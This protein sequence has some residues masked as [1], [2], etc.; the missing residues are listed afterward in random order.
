M[1]ERLIITINCDSDWEAPPR[2]NEKWTPDKYAHITLPTFETYASKIRADLVVVEDDHHKF[3][4]PTPHF[5]LFECFDYFLS[6]QY[7][8][9]LYLDLDIKI[10]KNAPNVF[11][12][13]PSGF[14]IAE[15]LPST[16]GWPA[17]DYKT[18]METIFKKPV[19]S[20]NYFNSGVIL[21]DRKS[22]EKFL[23]VLAACPKKMERLSYLG[24]FGEQHMVNYL[25]NESDMEPTVLDRRFND[26][27]WNDP[28]FAHYI[29]RGKDMLLNYPSGSF[30][31][32]YSALHL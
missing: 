15:D 32:Q 29:G 6:K 19:G 28:F 26:L 4:Y 24:G 17:G 18:W 7:S 5:L 8:Q 2:H 25:L 23:T 21:S 20:F 31:F 14:C 16:D 22:A 1:A 30:A 10:K 3:N 12:Q 11:D 13:Y 27:P 9:M